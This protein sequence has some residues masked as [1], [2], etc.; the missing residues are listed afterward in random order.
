M[1]HRFIETK[2]L[3][4]DVAAL[5]T[6]RGVE[7]ATVEDAALAL[8]RILSDPK[9]NGRAVAIVPRSISPSGY[10]DIDHDDYEEGTFLGKLQAG[11]GLIN[12]RS[13]VSS[14][15]HPKSRVAHLISS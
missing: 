3:S 11:V 14:F 6:S 1:L 8:L 15:V 7:F 2:I 10:Q 5:L 13:S 12:H 4:K 9:V